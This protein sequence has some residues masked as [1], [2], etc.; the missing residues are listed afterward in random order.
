MKT[1]LEIPDDVFRRAKSAAAERGIPLRELVT[2]AVK[3]KLDKRSKTN[4]KP[5]MAGFGK[6]RGLRKENARLT[7]I[8]ESEFE[9]I[10]AE[11]QL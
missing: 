1:T 7:R 2:E 11:D 10:E 6:L 5:W 4:A 3:D 8:I 9:Q